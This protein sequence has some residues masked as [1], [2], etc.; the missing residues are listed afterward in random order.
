MDKIQAIDIIQ[1]IF[2]SKFDKKRYIAFLKNLLNSYDNS[3]AFSQPK[4]GSLIKESFRDCINSFDRIGR[5]TCDEKVIDLLIVNLNRATSIERARSAQRNFVAGYLKGYYGSTSTKDAALVAFVSPDNEDWRFSLVKMDYR[6]EGK[7]GKTRVVEEFTPARRWSFLV[8]ANEKSHTAQSRLIPILL[9]D[10]KNPSLSELEEAFNIETVT[11]EFF[12]EYRSLFIR[13]KEELDKV[14]SKDPKIKKEFLE[15]GVNSVDF[16]KKTMGQIIFLYF[17]QK[18]GWFGV[19]RDK[20]WGSGP[21]NFLRDLFDGKHKKYKNFFNDILEPL[22]YEALAKGEREGDYYGNFNCRIP[23]LNGGLFDPIQGYDW[24]HTDIVLSD[25]LFSNADKTKAGDT[26][27]GILDVFDRF[28]FTVREDEPLE[29]EVAI[30]PEMLGKIFEK[31]GAVTEE[32]FTDW[33]AAVKTGNKAKENEANKKLGVYYTPREIVHYMCQQSLVSYLETS[34]ENK[35]SRKDL[36]TFICH[37]DKI[38][39]NDAV[40]EKKGKET[41]TYKRKLP[42]SVRLNSEIID[43]NLAEIKTCDPAIGSGAFPLGIMNEIVKAR[44]ALNIPGEE[45]TAYHFKRECIENSLYGVDID[46]GAVEIAKLRLWLSLVVDEEDPKNIHP[47][48]NLDYKIMQGNSL[49]DEYEG[50]KLFDEKIIAG[51]VNDISMRLK[52]LQEKENEIQKEYLP[53]LSSGKKSYKRDEL[54]NLLKAIKKEREFMTKQPKDTDK[55]DLY[56]TESPASEMAKELKSLHKEYFNAVHKSEKAKLKNE[57]DRL[58]WDLIQASL[59]EDNNMDGLKKLAELKKKRIRQYFLWKLYYS[60]VFEQNGGFDVVIG[61]PPYIQIQSLS[62]KPEQKQFEKANYKTYTRMGDIYCLFYERGF[63]LLARNGVLC[64]ITSNKWMRAGYGNSMRQYFLTN[65]QISQLIDFGDSKIFENATTYT[66]I[67]IWHKEKKGHP[68]MWDMSKSY[69]DGNTL[70]AMLEKEGASEALFNEGSFVLAKGSQASLKE[71]MEKVGTRLKDWDIQIYRGI[72]TGLNEA[73]IIDGKKRAE[74]IAADPKSEEIIKP[75]LRGRDIKRY[76]AEFADLWLVASHNGYRKTKGRNVPPVNLQK[77]Y[78]AVY[79][80]FES[81]GK[82]IQREEIKVKGKGLY[83]RDDQGHHWSNLRDC[84]YYEEFGKEKIMYAEIVYDS[85]F[86]Y[87]TKGIYPEATTF[88]I[89]GESIKY[90]TA[91][92]NSRLLTY[93][94][95]KFYAGGD[96]RGETFRYKKVFLEQLPVP[97]IPSEDQKPFITLVDQILNFTGSKGYLQDQKKQARVKE[98]E[99]EIDRLVYELYG[100]SED[101]IRIVEGNIARKK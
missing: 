81:V 43:R 90:I 66:N 60:E 19:E 93:V 21:K 86:Y 25:F 48:P 87:D 14:I 18:K 37:G 7:D 77:E 24:V 70:D 52:A 12:N 9:N 96:L 74:L 47:L 26:G 88:I 94:F 20:D 62:G 100:L 34:L 99:A 17:L 80:Y 13:F 63:N 75:I 22:F 3:K 67:L 1:G 89:T 72:L 64:Y 76:R 10:E 49:I 41:D 59:K 36:V 68:K 45:R 38:L 33:A 95:K 101:E 57:I 53:L 84:A 27:T 91:I 73:F 16:A 98:L 30:D 2:E 61:N 29:K 58:E 56:S 69:N 50:V 71:H 92:L 35:V 55:Q 31:L 44:K 54:E 4:S 83:E 15:Q 32:K 82:A 97:K 79:E 85:A 51:T 23:F 46:P 5:Y 11:K 28:N 65:G 42:E 8:G 78:P 39:E 6:F 40:V